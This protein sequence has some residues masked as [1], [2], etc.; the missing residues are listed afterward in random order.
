[1]AGVGRSGNQLGSFQGS[2]YHFI[3]DTTGQTSSGTVDLSGAAL[4]FSHELAEGMSYDDQ[5]VGVTVDSSPGDPTSIAN[6]FQREQ[7]ADMEPEAYYYRLDGIKVAPYFSNADHGDFIVPD[8]NKQQMILDANDWTVKTNPDSTTTAS[9]G[10]H[11]NLTIQGDQ[12]GSG[13]NDVLTINATAA[14]TQIILNG[15]FFNFDFG[16]LSNI[17]VNLGD[18]NDRVNI[19]G[20]TGEN[21]T[22]ALGTGNDTV[23]IGD[24]A[25][26]LDLIHGN[27]SVTGGTGTDTL[28]VND[29]NALFGHVWNVSGSSILRSTAASIEY[30]GVTNLVLHGGQ[31]NDTFILS[32]TANNL[33]E[34]PG[35][36]VTPFLFGSQ[37][38]TLQID[39]GA[40]ANSLILNDQNNP[41]SSLWQVAGNDVTRSCSRKIGFF[42]FETV[43][44]SVNYSNVSDL[45]IHAGQGNDTF[46]LSPTAQDLSELP[47]TSTFPFLLGSSGGTLQIDGGSGTNSLILSDQ[48]NPN[49]S[50]WDVTGK[51]VTRSYS[52]RIGA[53]LEGVSS[54]VN[55]S[56]IANLI[57]HAGKGDDTITLSPTAENLD[58]LPGLNVSSPFPLSSLTNSLTVDGGSG[59]NMLILDDQNTPIGSSWAVTG[60]NVTRSYSKRLGLL[61]E[62]V[63]SSINYSNVAH[64]ALHAGKG[65]DTITLSPTALNLDGLPGTNEIPL[66]FG[67]TGST[68]TVDGGAGT[69]SLI[70]DDQKNPFNSGWNVTDNSVTR[71][72]KFGSLFSPTVSSSIGYSNVSNVTI[73]AGSGSNSFLIS[74]TPA[75]GHVTVNGG[76]GANRLTTNNGNHDFSISGHDAGAYANV[77]FANIGSLAGGSGVDIFKFLPAGKLDGTING[78]GA[79]AGQ[80]DWLDYSAFGAPVTVDLATG[81]ATAVTGGVSNI[82]NV[83]G[84]AGNDTLT[85][86]A[87]GNILIGGAGTNVITGG[88]GRSLLIGG[89]GTSLI[90][91]GASDD[92][93]IAGTTTFDAN[94]TALMAIL[95]E[96]QRTDKTYAQR[97]ADLRT[98]SGFN[99]SNKLILG[100]TVLDNDKA[101][102]LTGGSGL[103][104]FFADLG[105]KGTKDLITDLAKG[106]VM[107]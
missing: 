42:L 86:N 78:G 53:L 30:T 94:E 9:F 1:L 25:A 6:G 46:N 83:I 5:P 32:P 11:Y 31:G 47:G 88:S 84:S 2:N 61:F 74:S 22:I 8:A 52:Q 36:N 13:T 66:L 67:S 24:T 62:L 45:S 16:V 40:G 14:G 38:S 35:V 81:S 97:I 60:N 76:S 100:T 21:V 106:E 56:N 44:F 27:I 33:D 70:F 91:G 12:F 63:S 105:S 59:N 37:G 23:N 57:L 28:I 64:L 73:N 90:T 29:H 65:N 50:A 69:N 19:D 79:P 95:K 107:N 93:L 82:Q 20:L 17:H 39:G 15:E 96:W 55:Y 92:I 4:T 26:N 18:G 41:N 10:G 85:G 54:T 87:L 77:S 68:F 49:N 7:I 43:S 104:W 48:D 101:S 98:G 51:A 80:G 72:H 89:T 102:L 3:I 71:S 58:E 34:L 103:D 99:G 75:T